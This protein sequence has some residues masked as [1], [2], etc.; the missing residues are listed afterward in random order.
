MDSNQSAFTIDNDLPVVVRDVRSPDVWT[1]WRLSPNL[2]TREGAIRRKR[3]NRKACAILEANPEFFEEVSE[4]IY[5]DLG[6]I[7]TK[8]GA[9]GALYAL[10]YCTHE[11][12]P[13]SPRIEMPPAWIRGD[14]EDPIT[15]EQMALRMLRNARPL[16]ERYPEAAFAVPHETEFYDNRVLFWAFVPHGLLRDARQAED[17]ALTVQGIGDE[18]APVLMHR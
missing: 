5:S 11:S 6:M 14:L 18:L 10:E 15:N 7:A 9:F 1:T 13:R 8:D 2:T 3:V 12:Y 16:V 17:F 4:G